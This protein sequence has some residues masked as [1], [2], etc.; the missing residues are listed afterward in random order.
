MPKP[1]KTD[2][3]GDVTRFAAERIR[4]LGMSIAM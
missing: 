4:R 2:V 3:F 1:P